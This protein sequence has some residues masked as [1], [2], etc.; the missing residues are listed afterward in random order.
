MAV[1][2]VLLHDLIDR[3]LRSGA[4]LATQDEMRRAVRSYR[5]LLDLIENNDQAA[6][7]AHWHR[8]LV[9]VQQARGTVQ[10]LDI[11]ED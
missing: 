3:Q 10:L 9:F 2:G 6:T 4:A 11:Y 1:L 8:Q 5:K 7:T